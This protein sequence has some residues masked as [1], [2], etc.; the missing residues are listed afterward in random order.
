MMAK[1]IQQ[2]LPLLEEISTVYK[3][4][5]Q[6]DTDGGEA[7]DTHFSVSRVTAAGRGPSQDQDQ[8]LYNRI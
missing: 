6:T 3:Q 1:D 5:V 8:E 4:W 2:L 7:Y